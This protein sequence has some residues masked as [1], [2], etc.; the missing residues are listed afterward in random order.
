[1]DLTEFNEE[2]VKEITNY[3]PKMGGVLISKEELRAAFLSVAA[4]RLDPPLIEELFT[5]LCIAL[6]L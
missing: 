3:R 4:G 1:M 6:S 2:H 5:E